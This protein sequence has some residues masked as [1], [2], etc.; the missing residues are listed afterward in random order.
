MVG[1]IKEES[2]VLETV[3]EPSRT[4]ELVFGI[5]GGIFGLLGG[6]AAVMIGS[7]G[8]AF[9]ASGSSD[10]IVLGVVTIIV[11]IAGIIGAVIVRNN[12]K[13]AGVLMILSGIIGFI[14]IFVFYIIGGFFLVLGGIM[15]LR[16]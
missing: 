15:A 6:I 16:K 2:R 5:I 9:N 13:L 7:F 4:L 14:C 1:E 11:S 12:H 10:I 8:E 3:N